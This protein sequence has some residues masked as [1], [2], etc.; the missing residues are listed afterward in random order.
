[1][2]IIKFDTLKV[3]GDFKPMNAVNNGPI[4][5]RHA[6]DQ[7]RTNIDAFTAAKIPFV[8]NHDASFENNYGSD[9]TVDISAVFPNFDA[10]P[11]DESSYDF[12]CTDEYIQVTR[13]T[14]AETFYRLGQRIEHYVKKYG[15]LPPKDFQKWAVICEHVIRHYNEGWANGFHFDMKYWEIWN[16]PDLDAD[17]ALN[18]RTWG[19][20]KAQFFDLFETA[21]KHLKKCFPSLKIGGPAIAGNMEWAAEFLAEMRRRCVPI[22]FFSWHIYTVEPEQLISRADSVKQMLID[23]G[24]DN[25]ESILNEWNYVEDWEDKFIKS[26]EAIT[27]IK[28]AAFS[29]ACMSLGQ[30]SSID[31]LM[32]YDA[33]P[34]PF[35]GLFDFYTLRPLRGY[36][37]F[38]WYGMMYGRKEIRAN[39][40]PN[41][42]YT[43]CGVDGEGKTLTVLTHY[44]KDDGA[45]A[46]TVRIDFGK[47]AKYDV[48]ILDA[49]HN[50]TESVETDD[51]TFTLPAESCLLIREK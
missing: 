6:T 1:M 37:P 34:C 51:L 7:K 30:R 47:K 13:L 44:S 39:F 50:G 18:K 21:A 8:R 4:H 48:F 42:I 15:T 16:E 19:G 9:H 38:M 36:Y 2:D 40:E 31:M 27:G 45:A 26:I 46:Q 5:K 41:G 35:N 11:Y 20:N 14:G 12:A 23:N 3:Y 29:M 22:D 49:E 33:R 28:G 10:D 17:D 32:Y 24:Y 43:L 25:A